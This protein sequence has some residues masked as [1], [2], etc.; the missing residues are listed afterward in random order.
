VT[1]AIANIPSQAG[2]VAA[3]IDRAAAGLKSARTSAEL[4]DVIG[5]T[6]VA[7]TAAKLAARAAKIKGAFD[8][9]IAA[10]YRAQADALE[11]EAAAKRR[12]ADEL[13]QSQK[14]GSART[15]GGDR[16]SKL[17]DGKFAPKEI[18]LS[19]KQI[20]EARKIRDA[21]RASPGIVRKTLDS[22]LNH[23]D[24]P[25]KAAVRRAVNETLGKRDKPKKLAPQ[26]DDEGDTG[27][28]QWHRSVENLAGESVALQAMWTRIFGK[29]WKTYSVPSELAT[30]A[31]EAA[32]AWKQIA[33]DLDK[34][35]N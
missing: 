1:T 20:H 22:A 33:S 8:D 15:R 24:E 28:E 3:L 13:D 18:G 34:R 10:A 7:Y 9:V 6:D 30:L 5:Q 12:L 17:S 2:N 4:L 21:E 14:D 32:D 19:D 16:T 27:E 23:G 11:I 35:S 29:N 31:R 25:T 26:N